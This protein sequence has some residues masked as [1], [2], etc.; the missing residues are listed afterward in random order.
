MMHMH[1][2]PKS[3]HPS[4]DKTYTTG[5]EEKLGVYVKEEIGI[6]NMTA[7][8]GGIYITR[9]IGKTQ[10]GGGTQTAE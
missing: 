3:F 9:T 7:K 2:P 5:K 10:R 8:K 6:Q 1:T 4:M